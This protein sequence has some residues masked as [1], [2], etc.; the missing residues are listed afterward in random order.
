MG[1][2]WSGGGA[3]RDQRVLHVGVRRREG[4]G[5]GMS[6]LVMVLLVVVLVVV[7]LV[8]TALTMYA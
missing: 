6:G 5:G 1:T 4:R 2:V 8:V 3:G 7:A